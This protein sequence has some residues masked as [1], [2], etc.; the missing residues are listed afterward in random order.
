VS[1]LVFSNQLVVQR[2]RAI[3]TAR[4]SEST[5]GGLL[6]LSLTVLRDFVAVIS[7]LNDRFAIVITSVYF[8][9]H[10]RLRDVS[11]RLIASV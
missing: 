9:R 5:H 7:S 8:S 10:W 3:T 6:Y 2:P 11:L 4:E 1:L